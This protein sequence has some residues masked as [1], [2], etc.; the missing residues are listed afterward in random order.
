MRKHRIIALTKRESMQ[1]IAEIS[2]YLGVPF[3]EYYRRSITSIANDVPES[4]GDD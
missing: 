3:A 4:E 2:L 1:K